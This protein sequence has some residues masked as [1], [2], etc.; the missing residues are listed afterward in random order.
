MHTKLD[1]I[2]WE[3]DLVVMGGDSCSKGCEFESQH[4]ILDEHF[5]HLF[6]VKIVMC[7]RRDE[8]KRKNLKNQ[9]NELIEALK[10]N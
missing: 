2:Q 10:Y 1:K 7:V 3:P 4:S 9:D 8:N 5:S 6:V